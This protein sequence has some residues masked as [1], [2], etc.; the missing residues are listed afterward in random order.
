MALMGFREN[1]RVL[2]RGVRPAH[3][4][5]QVAVPNSATNAEV[6]IYTVPAGTIFHLTWYGFSISALAA[7]RGV[8]AI[9]DDAPAII[10]YLAETNV[11]LAVNTPMSCC[12]LPFPIELL[13]DYT[14]RIYSS[15]AGL[16]AR[17][18]IAGWVE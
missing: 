8:L 17:G 16:T 14:V 3:N 12:G 7:G 6:V 10:A 15:A 1:N 18:S 5:T 4:G 13:P 9:Y 11:V 2:W